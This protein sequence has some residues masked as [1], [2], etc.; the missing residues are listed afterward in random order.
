[1]LNFWTDKDRWKVLVDNLKDVEQG[2]GIE[3]QPRSFPVWN[4][5]ERL[6]LKTSVAWLFQ[7]SWMENDAFYDNINDWRPVR[8]LMYVAHLHHQSDLL[9][10]SGYD[11]N[12]ATCFY[13]GG[14]SKTVRST[15]AFASDGLYRRCHVACM[16]RLS[17]PL[18]NSGYARSSLAL[19]VHH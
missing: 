7:M 1:M 8:C 17:D 6:K 10:E 11:R 9:Y 13:S 16:N 5:T 15:T 3:R 14:L 19:N 18:Y 12:S 2:W 4:D